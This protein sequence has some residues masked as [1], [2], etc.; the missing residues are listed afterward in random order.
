MLGVT[1]NMG[2][3]DTSDDGKYMKDVTEVCNDWFP[4]SMTNSYLSG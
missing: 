3:V 1:H 2:F 4:Y